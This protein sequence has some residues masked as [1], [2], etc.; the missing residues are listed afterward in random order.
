MKTIPILAPSRQHLHGFLAVNAWINPEHV[1]LVESVADIMN[2]V[3]L[4]LAMRDWQHSPSIVGPR[5]ILEYIRS[6]PTLQLV[7]IENHYLPMLGITPEDQL[8]A[9]GDPLG[10]I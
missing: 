9:G 8:V 7:A 5:T 10:A 1:V 2:R 4:V 6:E 3:G